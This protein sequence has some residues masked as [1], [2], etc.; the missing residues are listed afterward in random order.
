MVGGVLMVT[1]LESSEKIYDTFYSSYRNYIKGTVICEIDDVVAGHIDIELNSDE[2]IIYIDMIEVEDEYRRKGIATRM[3]YYLRNTYPD[4]YIDWGWTTPDGTA[5]KDKL[6]IT[7]IS[8][9]YIELVK[10]HDEVEKKL[11]VV[12]ELLNDKE[13]LL[14]HNEEEIEELG[15][16]W[17]KLYG[18]L[19]DIDDELS[20][21]RKD[22]TV[23]R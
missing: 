2:N 3:L 17:D 23:W 19:N 21:T 5:L 4:F 18:E 1:L 14:S 7:Q 20:D 12:E 22:V 16:K 13:W 8:D 10:M 6:T 9:H 11:S 15:K